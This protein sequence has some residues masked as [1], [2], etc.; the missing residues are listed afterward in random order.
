MSEKLASIEK[1]GGGKMSETTLWTNPNTSVDFANQGVTLSDNISNYSYIKISYKFSRAVADDTAISVII[2]ETDFINS[3]AAEGTCFAGLNEYGASS[4][5]NYSW[6]RG[7]YPTSDTIVYF[8]GCFSL[9]ANLN[10]NA[11]CIPIEIIGLK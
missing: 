8:T 6:S 9:R 7:V 4:G 3:N 5:T 11:R 10:Q 2:N 1:K